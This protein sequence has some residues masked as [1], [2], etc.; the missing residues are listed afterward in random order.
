M[1][2][3]TRELKTKIERDRLEML[4]KT[5]QRKYG[6]DFILQTFLNLNEFQTL[7]QRVENDDEFDEKE[8]I[9]LLMRI[10]D[11]QTKQSLSL[12]KFFHP[13]MTES[14]IN[15]NQ[16]T[17]KNYL[18][19]IKV[20]RTEPL[21]IETEKQKEIVIFEKGTEEPKS[22]LDVIMKNRVIL[23]NSFE[24]TSVVEW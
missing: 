22:K 24:E 11:S 17:T 5:V 10:L 20:E 1:V 16:T 4:E 13:I 12:M 14:N 23:P 18:K 3:S 6:Y 19:V 2:K 15:T 8:K 7:K 21:G 9:E